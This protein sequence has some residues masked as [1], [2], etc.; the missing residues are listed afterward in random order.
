MIQEHKP[1]AS[2]SRNSSSDQEDD[3][4]FLHPS[5][6]NSTATTTATRRHVARIPK[7]DSPNPAALIPD[8]AAQDDPVR[9]KTDKP[10]KTGSFVDLLVTNRSCWTLVVI[11][12]A[13]TLAFIPQV[14]ERFF[15]KG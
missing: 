11:L 13:A 14:H 1:L 7:P 5:P 2:L 8:A 4:A 10:R 6:I 15:S 12:L 3:L 9:A